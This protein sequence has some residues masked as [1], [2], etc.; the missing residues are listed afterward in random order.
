MTD[1]PLPEWRLDDLYESPDSPALAN[2][3]EHAKTRA[4]A[5]AGRCRSR[6]AALDGAALA[7]A[8]AEYEALHDTLGRVMSYAA[9]RFAADAGAPDAGSVLQDMR[10]KTSAIEATLLFMTLE[11]ARLDDDA[12][13]AKLETPALARYAPWI[14]RVRAFRDH[15]LGDD[16]ERLLHEKQV[17]GRD[18]WVRLFDETSARLR[19]PFR[20]EALTQARAFDLLSSPDGRTRRAAAR[21]IS[22]VLA[23]NAPAFALILDTLVKDKAVEDGWRSYPRPISSRNLENEVED[24]VVDMLVATVREACPRLSHRY[25]ALKARWLGADALNWWDRNAPAARKR[26][27]AD[28]VAGGAPHGARRLRETVADDGPH[29]RAL[30]RRRL[31]RCPAAAGEGAGAFSHPVTPSAHPYILLN[32]RGRPRDVMT[33]AHELG[34]GVHQSL[35]GARGAL[36]AETPLTLDETASVFGE[37]LVFRS[38]LENET[39]PAAPPRPASPARSRTCSIP[40]CDRPRSANSNAACTTAAPNGRSPPTTSATCGWKSRAKASAPAVRLDD[41]YRNWWSY[42][43]QFRPHAILRLRL[44]VRRMSRGRA[45][46]GLARGAGELRRPLSRHLARRRNAAL[47]RIPRAVRPRRPRTRLLAPRPR[48]HRGGESTNSNATR[49]P[50]L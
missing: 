23:D 48:R 38:L 2:D 49:P 36:M 41:D 50:R 15:R 6:L 22:R 8:I 11:I 1:A 45:L 32:Y 14:R 5:L 35:A 13:A 37:Q 47:R 18:A 26:R 31:D 34:H 16:L 39:D 30:L 28:A 3:L 25:Y 46:F 44:C 7:D 4:A 17:A 21:S 27:P 10:E 20:G 43:P 40:R 9:L 24:E 19:F 42:I 12:L 29:R 33:L